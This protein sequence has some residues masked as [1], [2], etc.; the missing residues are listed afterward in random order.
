M[1]QGS[2]NALYFFVCCLLRII[3]F[4]ALQERE[5]HGT[6][7]VVINALQDIAFSCNVAFCTLL[8]LLIQC[9]GKSYCNFVG[10]HAEIIPISVK[11]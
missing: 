4:A 2:A 3:A 9:L 6:H 8:E 11:F 7:A 5:K 1:A 10:C